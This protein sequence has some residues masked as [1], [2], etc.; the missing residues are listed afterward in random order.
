MF[1][2]RSEHNAIVAL[3]REQRDAETARADKQLEYNRV[4]VERIAAMIMDGAKSLPSA[5]TA[6]PERSSRQNVEEAIQ[7]AS[8][9][10]KAHAAVL[11]VYVA[12]QRADGHSDAEIATALLQPQPADEEGVPV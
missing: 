10:N 6:P 7:L 5:P 9:G 11:R 2:M 3:L 4:L 12:S 8:S 1:M